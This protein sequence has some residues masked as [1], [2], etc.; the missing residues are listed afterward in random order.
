M[1][2]AVAIVVVAVAVLLWLAFV[3]QGIDRNPPARR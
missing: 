3:G 2:W 1:I